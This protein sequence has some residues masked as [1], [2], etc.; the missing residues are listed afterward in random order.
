[1][2]FASHRIAEGAARMQD[3]ITEIAAVA[4]QSSAATEEVSASTQETS[5]FTEQIA[6]SA[7]NR[8]DTAVTLEQLV[9]RFR[10][11]D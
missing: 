11:T 8:S 3:T 9:A 10:V 2:R 5:A 4:E 7:H 6:A 1:M